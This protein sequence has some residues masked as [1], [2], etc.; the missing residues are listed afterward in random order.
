LDQTLL[1]RFTRRIVAGVRAVD[2]DRLIFYEPNLLFDV[3]APTGLGDP[4]DSD[5]G[6]SYH[7]YCVQAFVS[8][9]RPSPD[10]PCRAEERRVIDNARTQ[11]RRTGDTQML[12]E[13]GF[14]PNAA[15]RIT[16]LADRRML[17]WQWW[18]YYGDHLDFVRPALPNLIRPYPQVIAGTPK[19]WFYNADAKRF[20]LVY[21]TRRVGGE[22]AGPA[23]VATG[24]RYPAGT[25]TTVFVPRVHFP[26]GYRVEVDGA[27]V[28]SA[29]R[30]RRLLL[31]SCAG[32]RQVTVRLM[33]GTTPASARSCP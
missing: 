17:N 23:P 5:A 12:S 10:V 29:P 28:V 2:R 4:G 11:I 33:P 15:R 13:A 26:D 24:R 18:D 20:S 6:L 19:R 21:S 32:A 16:E 31:A 3:G 9:N 25:R 8:G 30:A 14:D 7:A 22:G 27:R 1:T